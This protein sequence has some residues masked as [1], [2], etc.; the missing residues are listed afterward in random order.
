MLIEKS[1]KFLFLKKEFIIIYE[2]YGWSLYGGEANKKKYIYNC[3]KPSSHLNKVN[4]AQ[5]SFHKN[6]SSKSK[7]GR[8]V[9][10]SV[11][12]FT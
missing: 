11:Y 9:E 2:N 1:N 3:C 7:K 5:I 8:R 4:M 6:Y 12:S 10:F